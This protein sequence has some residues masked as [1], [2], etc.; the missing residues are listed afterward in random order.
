MQASVKRILS[1]ALAAAVLVA[2]FSLLWYLTRGLTAFTTESWRRFEVL[3]AARPL[4]AVQLQDQAGQRFELQSLCGR[5]LVINFIYTHCPGV[6]SALGAGAAQLARSLDA[7]IEQERVAV[8]SVSFDPLRDT[9]KRLASFKQSLDPSGS[10]WRVLRAPSE[11]QTQALLQ[12]MGVVVIDDRRGGFVH[13]A[14]WHMVDPSCRLTRILDLD[15]LGRAAALVR[16]Q[17]R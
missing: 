17:L 2:G 16:E 10:G 6:C 13:N 15:E 3:E 14:A 8:L 11:A 4:P 12:T 5:V 1:G 9:P 7:E